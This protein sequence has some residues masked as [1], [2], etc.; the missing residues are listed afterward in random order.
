[1]QLLIACGLGSLVGLSALGL[2][3]A[4]HSV[5]DA[6]GMDF[7]LIGLFAMMIAIPVMGYANA[8]WYPV[9]AAACA[10]AIYALLIAAYAFVKLMHG[11]D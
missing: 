1:M 3:V 10:P 7:V 4:S 9:A 2:R 6:S 11:F 5:D 8:Q